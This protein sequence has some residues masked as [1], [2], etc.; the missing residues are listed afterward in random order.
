MIIGWKNARVDIDENKLNV[1]W[2]ECPVFNFIIL[3]LKNVKSL[4]AGNIIIL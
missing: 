1:D 3:I 4:N 2:K